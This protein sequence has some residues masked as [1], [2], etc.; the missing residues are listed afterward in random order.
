[1]KR[2]LNWIRRTLDHDLSLGYARQLRWLC[3]LFVIVFVLIIA[4]LL[5][6]VVVDKDFNMGDVNLPGTAFLLL[7]DPGNLSGVLPSNHSWIIGII[8]A[9]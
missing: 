2:F 6:I 4:T 3:L 5:V 1:M 9:L 8:Y 7:T